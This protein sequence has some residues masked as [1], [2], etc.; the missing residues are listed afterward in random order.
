MKNLLKLML[1]AVVAVSALA[2]VGCSKDE[3]D[4]SVGKTNEGVGTSEPV[5]PR[6]RDGGTAR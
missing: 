4:T 1:C 2:V 5:T 3:V 6:N